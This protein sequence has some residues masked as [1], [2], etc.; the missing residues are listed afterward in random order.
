MRQPRNPSSTTGNEQFL[1]NGGN[2]VARIKSFQVYDRWGQVV[3]EY[4]DFLPGD[5]ASAWN[6]KVKGKVANPAVFVYYAEIEFK[7]G[8]TVLY[9]GDVMV[10]H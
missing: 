10:M 5:P 6:G 7:D 1:I 3:H 8:E 9:K 2:D 4:F